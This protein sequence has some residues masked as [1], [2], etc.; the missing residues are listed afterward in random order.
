[1]KN[2]I[3]CLIVLTAMTANMQDHGTSGG[4]MVK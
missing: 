4:F 3:Y 1:M 2:L